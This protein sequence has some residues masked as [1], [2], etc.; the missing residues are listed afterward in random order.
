MFIK[1]MQDMSISL[2]WRANPPADPSLWQKGQHGKKETRPQRFQ[3]ETR[4]GVANL[5]KG[6]HYTAGISPARGK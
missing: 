2:R 5:D 3:A 4:A 1:I 6:T